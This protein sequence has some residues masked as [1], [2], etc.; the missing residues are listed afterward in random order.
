MLKCDENINCEFSVFNFTVGIWVIAGLC[1]SPPLF[2]Y[3][4]LRFDYSTWSYSCGLECH[5]ELYGQ[6]LCGSVVVLAILVFEGNSYGL[7]DIVTLMLFS[8]S[9]VVFKNVFA[10]A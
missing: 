9:G 1:N 8:D 3:Q 7:I 10:I 5:Q 4:G 6:V 2:N